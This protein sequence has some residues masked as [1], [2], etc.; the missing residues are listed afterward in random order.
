MYLAL[1]NEL[2]AI[3][4]KR[5][6]KEDEWIEGAIS[7]FVKMCPSG[8]L[9][10]VC[11]KQSQESWFKTHVYEGVRVKIFHAKDGYNRLM[12]GSDKDQALINAVLPIVTCMVQEAWRVQKLV[13]SP[14][15]GVITNDAFQIWAKRISEYCT[16]AVAGSSYDPKANSQETILPMKSK[17]IVRNRAPWL[18]G[19]KGSCPVSA[20]SAVLPLQHVFIMDGSTAIKDAP[21]GVPLNLTGF[22]EFEAQI[23]IQLRN[24]EP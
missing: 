9:S 23:A 5:E 21:L 2:S 10:T 17:P 14:T 18:A 13:R 20:L 12:P 15:K 8:V 4:P 22:D 3:H 11:G 24:G 7:D 6:K 1:E 16:L 19:A